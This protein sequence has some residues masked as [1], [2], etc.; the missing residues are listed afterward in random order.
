MDP[1]AA[2]FHRGVLPPWRHSATRPLMAVSNADFMAWAAEAGVVTAPGLEVADCGGYR[3]VKATVPT[4][5]G[6]PL[7]TVPA[8]QT[9][10]TTTLARTPPSGFSEPGWEVPQ[11]AWQSSPWYVRL[12]LL[13]LKEKSL[14]DASPMALWLKALPAPSD[15]SDLPMYWSPEHREALQHEP[16]GDAADSQAADY[17]A[18]L[19]ALQSKS[20]GS[21]GSGGLSAVSPADFE[22]AVHVV[23]SRA[24]S[25]PYEGSGYVERV[26]TAGFASVLAVGAVASGAAEVS[27]VVNGLLAVLLTTV[28]RDFLLSSQAS[29]TRYVLCPCVI[30]THAHSPYGC[31]TCFCVLVWYIH[32]LRW[33]GSC[34]VIELHNFCSTSLGLLSP[35]AFRH[36]RLCN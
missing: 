15:F 19:A 14:G 32:S 21:S 26:A 23:R 3:G 9:L 24:F 5:A 27:Q 16:L 31:G 22:W 20:A 8:K 6:K 25:G 4:E 28:L 7:V 13:L 17:R 30:F 1:P 18:A 11:E 35:L 33:R 34:V 10:V 2:K 29:L 12:A 36:V